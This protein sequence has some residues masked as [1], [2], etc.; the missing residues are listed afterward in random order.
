[1]QQRAKQKGVIF[2]A[3]MKIGFKR[4][5]MFDK[6]RLQQIFINLINNAIKFTPEG[7]EVDFFIYVDV[8]CANRVNVIFIVRD[9]GI[10]MSREFQKKMFEPF[11]QE[12]KNDQAGGTGL[13]LS[14]VKQLLTLMGGSIHCESQPGI[15]TE[16][17]V[18][19][20]TE[21]CEDT[22]ET[23]TEVGS[24]QQGDALVG[25]RIL[26]CEDQPI[27]A[28]ICKA[29][30]EKM[31]CIV[32]HA[33]NGKVCVE[34]FRKSPVAYYDAIL[35]DIRMPVLNGFEAAA[36]IRSLV[37]KDATTVP[38][39]ALSANSSDEDVQKSLDAGMDAHIGK[40]IDV[41]ELFRVLVDLLE[42]KLQ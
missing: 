34:L 13:G 21:I 18:Q 7:G 28:Q 2:Q 38:M 4:A 8:F 27:N 11:E 12:N 30:L 26:L 23:N 33:E 5:V 19:I 24:F 16:F 20:E 39:I 40:A 41:G 6:L 9:T 36:M 32:E 37:R 14:I 3:Q 22:P 31:G 15:G 1:M 35:M 42:N 25:K 10:G 29:L 17:V